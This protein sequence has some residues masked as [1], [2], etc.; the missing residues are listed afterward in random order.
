MLF[1]LVI[2][3]WLPG[4]FIWY[5]YIYSLVC[6][7]V[8]AP[9]PAKWERTVALK[10]LH[11]FNNPKLTPDSET[12]TTLLIKGG[13]KTDFT[14]AILRYGHKFMSW[15]VMY[16][17]LMTMFKYSC[18]TETAETSEHSAVKSKGKYLS[19]RTKQSSYHN[20]PSNILL[21]WC[22][23]VIKTYISIVVWDG[24]PIGCRVSWQ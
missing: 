17:V 22:V 9:V 4:G 16:C 8:V 11:A 7:V 6:F 18:Y 24:T 12:L 20:S 5:I 2:V 10:L 19:N 23:I 3:A 15:N 1:C 14:H 21:K 13:H